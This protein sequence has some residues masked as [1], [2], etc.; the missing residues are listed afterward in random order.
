VRRAALTAVAVAAAPALLALAPAPAAAWQRV[1]TVGELCAEAGARPITRATIVRGRGRTGPEE[2]IPLESCTIDVWAGAVLRLADV[3]VSVQGSGD[4]FHPA[5]GINLRGAA[6]L[7]LPRSTLR[8]YSAHVD[9]AAGGGDVRLVASS[10]AGTETTA[11]IVTRGDVSIRRSHIHALRGGGVES[12]GGVELLDTSIG[13]RNSISIIAGPGGVRIEGGHVG[14][15]L[16]VAH[17]VARRGGSITVVEARLGAA[18]FVLEP[19]PSGAVGAVVVAGVEVGPHPSGDPTE[20]RILLANSL[21]RL[22][23][24]PIRESLL[25]SWRQSGQKQDP[26]PASPNRNATYKPR[27]SPYHDFAIS[28]GPL[29]ATARPV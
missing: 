23:A 25:A 24:K 7:E 18:E 13:G 8:A 9:G 26:S 20:Q 16:G 29:C 28:I 2:S 10:I 5:P 11:G 4:A 27:L 15:G 14:G 22:K 3:A 21:D 6:R 17:I 19:A 1:A 12:P